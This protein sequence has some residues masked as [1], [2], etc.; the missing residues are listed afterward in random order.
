MQMR[1]SCSYVV[2]ELKIGK[3]VNIVSLVLDVILLHMKPGIS[4]SDATK[5]DMS[6]S[7]IE[8]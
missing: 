1:Y 5:V 6:I 2:G 4:P 8:S 7:K 3:N